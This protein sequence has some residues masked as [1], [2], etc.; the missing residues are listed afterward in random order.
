M[1][2]YKLCCQCN[3]WEFTKLLHL[4]RREQLRDNYIK[5]C[6]PYTCMAMQKKTWMTFFNLR[7]SYIFQ[8]VYS[9]WNVYNQLTLTGSK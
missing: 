8:V 7:N 3:K 2:D 6:K 1:V 4:N 5:L 9:K